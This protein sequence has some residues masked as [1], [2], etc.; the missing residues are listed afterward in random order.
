MAAQC[1]FPS[2]SQG[3]KP[4][5]ALPLFGFF[6]AAPVERISTYYRLVLRTSMIA[7]DD[8]GLL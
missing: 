5:A 7:F 1:R 4:R 8:F 3:V 6:K 2:I